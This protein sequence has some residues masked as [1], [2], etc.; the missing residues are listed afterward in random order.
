MAVWCLV[1]FLG[2]LSHHHMQSAPSIVYKTDCVSAVSINSFWNLNTRELILCHC[3]SI[4]M[5][6]P[7]V[8]NALANTAYD[9]CGW[10]MASIAWLSYRKWGSHCGPASGVNVGTGWR[11][12]DNG[13]VM[14][15]HDPQFGLCIAWSGDIK[16]WN[17][18]D[19]IVA[20][21]IIYKSLYF[22]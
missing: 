17:L 19:D 4:C 3:H 10:L 8:W 13:M 12:T 11:N 20:N 7:A 1:T 15:K 2:C 16:S 14:V 6:L 18:Q 21:R 9:H 22:D 5:H